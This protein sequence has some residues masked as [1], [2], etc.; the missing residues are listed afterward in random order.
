MWEK[1]KNQGRGRRVRIDSVRGNGVLGRADVGVKLPD[2]I[3]RGTVVARRQPP[4][5]TPTIPVLGAHKGGE[6]CGSARY[7]KSVGIPLIGGFKSFRGSGENG[8]EQITD[9]ASKR[10]TKM[11]EGGQICHDFG[12]ERSWAVST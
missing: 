4:A 9:A 3:P 8:S 1:R 6:G 11:Q 5:L 2:K 7:I 12:K 10:Y